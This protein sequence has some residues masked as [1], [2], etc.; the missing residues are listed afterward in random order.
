MYVGGE[1]GTG[2]SRVIHGVKMLVELMGQR[3]ML[4]LAGTT[5]AAADN[6]DSS[7]IHSCAGLNFDEKEK[8]P[9]IVGEQKMLKKIWRNK[10]ILIIDEA[11]MLSLKM[12]HNINY[13][14]KKLRD[15]EASFEGIQVI[16]LFGN[17]F[18]MPPVN[19]YALY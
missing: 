5:G 3:S 19:G 4:Q 14:C 18:Q 8:R 9:E 16:M 12:L 10:Q 17:F 13:K 1:G 6:I 7:T 11:S 15:N 2:K